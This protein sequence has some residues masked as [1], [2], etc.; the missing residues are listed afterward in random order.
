MVEAA[1][2]EYLRVILLAATQGVTEF[3]PI[4]SSGHLTVLGRWFDFDAESNLMLNVVLHAG[5]LLAIVAFYFRELWGILIDPA[6]RRLIWLVIVG[7]IPTGVIGVGIK[8]SGLET[9]LFDSLW[10][11]TAGFLITAMLLQWAFG[12]RDNR[13]AT[14]AGVRLE[15]FSWLRA[16]WI[17]VAQGIAITPGI[18]RS[19]ST[20]AAGVRLGLNK[21]DAAEFSFLLAIPA[22]GGAALLEGRDMVKTG[23][24][25]TV[26]THQLAILAVGFVIAA[27][28]GYVALSGLIA[29]LRR[30]RLVYFAYY[31][32]GAAAVV[33]AVQIGSG[34]WK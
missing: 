1:M 18:S 31:L 22:I 2:W 5:T 10:V 27:V 34:V 4:S 24:L 14:D 32:Y 6:R 9:R 7:T 33:A 26:D 28:V 30:G 29:M 13:D 20:I 23:V 25:G 15:Q 17:G 3:L 21:V 12:G 11:P 16:F 8:L 19:G